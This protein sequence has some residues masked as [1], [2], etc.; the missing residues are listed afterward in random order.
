MKEYDY[1]SMVEADVVVNY[2][3]ARKK[4]GDYTLTFLS[5]L[6]GTGKSSACLRLGE[7]TSQQLVDKNIITSDNI[8]DD[9]L[10]LID[11]VRKAKP[12]QLNIAIIE[13][14]SVLFPSRRAMAGDNVAV[15]QILDTARKKQVIIFANAP[16]WTSIDSHLRALGHV[17]VETLK[18]VKSAGV[19]VSKPLRLQTNPS[20]GKTYYHRFKR[21]GKEVQRIITRKP[22][23]DTWNE[24]EAKKDK[25]MDS[26]YERL[27]FKALKKED[28]LLKEMGKKNPYQF[29]R[30]LT[31]RESLVY[32]LYFGQGLK[33]VEI[34]RK[35]GMTTGGISVIVG[36]I[37][38]IMEIP[39]EF[40]GNQVIK[41]NKE[42]IK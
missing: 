2:I 4:H 38:K 28:K 42:A 13:E 30:K 40:K 15:G 20:S 16:L 3:C 19:V 9:L 34:S 8:I 31:E 24:Y 32:G 12:D 25:F 35:L 23:E 11:F 1:K 29:K 5:G 26:L 14:V 21:K 10:G 17:Y 36:R 22:N 18:L 7:L 27:Q 39:K 6:P 41:R 33:Q 37:R